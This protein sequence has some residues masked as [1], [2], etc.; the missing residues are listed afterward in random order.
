MENYA[1]FDSAIPR[2]ESWRPSQPK[3][4][5]ARDFRHLEKWRHFGRLAAKSPVSGEEYRYLIPKAKISGASLCSMKF[6][7]P[8]FGGRGSRD[9]LRFGEDRFESADVPTSDP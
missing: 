3:G 4:S 9:R 5:H 6:R 1:D 2:F 8:K 7:Y